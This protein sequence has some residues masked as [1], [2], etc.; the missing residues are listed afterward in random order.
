MDFELALLEGADG[1]GLAQ[2]VNEG[3]FKDVLLSNAAQKMLGDLD[4]EYLKARITIS[5]K[6]AL[7]VAVALLHSFV[8]I[9]WTGPELDY[10]LADLN[11][12]WADYDYQNSTAI[13]K[14]STGGEPAYHLTRCA[15]LL[16]ISQAIL[17]ELVKSDEGEL[18]LGSA[19]WWRLR[20]TLAQQHL[21]DDCVPLPQSMVDGVKQ[22]LLDKLPPSLQARLTLEIG[23]AYHMCERDREASETFLEAANF[24]QLKFH[25]TGAL[26]K[27]TK[28]QQS[29]ITQLVLLAESKDSYENT[30]DVDAQVKNLELN[31]DTLLEQTQFSSTVDASAPLSH[32]DPTMQ[33]KLSAVDQCILLAMCLNIKNTAPENGLTNSQMGAFV[34]RVLSNHQNWSIYT[35]GLLLRSRLEAHRTRTVQRS[36]LQLQALIDQMPTSDSSNV[37]RLKYFFAMP[38]PAKWE[39]ERELAQRFV[40]MGVVRSAL[41]IYQKLE[42]WEDTIICYVSTDRQS[43]ALDTVKGLLEGSI[44][45]SQTITTRAKS[46]VDSKTRTRMDV[47]RV[48]KFWCLYGDLDVPNCEHHYKKALEVSNGSSS[49]AWRSL[50]GL[51]FAKGDNKSTVEVLRNAVAINPLYHHTW[52]I[53]GCASIRLEDWDSAIEAFS[54]CVAVEDDDAESWNNLASVYLRLGDKAVVSDRQFCSRHAH[55]LHRPTKTRCLHSERSSRVPSMAS[56]TG[57][58]GRTS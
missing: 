34:Q 47:M 7:A 43:D 33:P 37:E 46:T 28:F 48:A 14:L 55:A 18:P 45:E 56:T 8:Q 35:M 39:L 20:A 50:G 52:F 12:L 31:D 54:R 15:P 58:S 16:L 3:K 40:A 53:L 25:L 26:G 4:L 19:R 6:D 13:H 41:E 24:N 57:V 5:E 32:I 1:N 30:K 11:G 17:D 23:I 2:L 29:D 36:T 9:N 21:L 10:S 42:M 27:R 22:A 38:M 49:R 51:Y 44:V